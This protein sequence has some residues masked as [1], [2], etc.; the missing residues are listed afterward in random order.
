MSNGLKLAL[1][2]FLGVI[3][4]NSGLNGNFGS[5]LAAIFAP[6]SL[7]IGQPGSSQ[8]AGAGLVSGNF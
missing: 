8:Q 1:M 6:D 3:F 4:I 2:L 7:I 5:V